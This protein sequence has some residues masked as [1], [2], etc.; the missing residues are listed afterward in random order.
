MGNRED[1]LDGAK[2]CL[3]EKGYSRTTARDIATAAGVSLAAI[4]YHYGS[5]DAL[6]NEA[7]MA[8]V[9][10][11]GD[12]VEAATAGAPTAPRERFVVVWDAIRA[13]MVEYRGIWAAQFEVIARMDDV[14]D[15]Q[16][17]FAGVQRLARLEIARMVGGTEG[18]GGPDAAGTEDDVVLGAFYQA[19]LAGVVTQWLVDPA[20]S[21]TGE[22]M[23]R[24]LE[25]AA[26]RVLGAGPDGG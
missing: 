10:G 9:A 14:P 22:Q 24:G 8:S 19:L 13:A 5:K 25:L 3:A 26:G 1:L 2:R 4:G 15:V 23:L 12:A 21:L 16:A 20:Q 18:I 17:S 11:W 6:L 7:M